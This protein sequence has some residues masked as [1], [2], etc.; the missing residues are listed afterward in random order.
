ML[1]IIIGLC[2]SFVSAQ[3]P[4][5]QPPSVS[6][7]PRYGT[8]MNSSSTPSNPHRPRQSSGMNMYEKDRMEIEQR[9]QTA[10]QDIEEATAWYKQQQLTDYLI[11]KGFPSQQN[12]TGATAFFSAYKEISDMLEGNT[13]IDMGRAIY[14]AE[15]A[16][17]EN[18]LNYDE[19]QKDI[20]ERVQLCQRRMKEL[21]LNPK[22]NMA[23]NMIIW[24]HLCD[25]L[26]MKQPGSEN[27]ITHYP[28][29]YNYDDFQ[30]KKD[31]TSH[32]V[33]TLIRT[34]K[35]NC[36]SMPLLYLMIAEKLGAEAYLSYAPLHS[37]VKIRDKKG[38][39]YNLEITNRYM[40]SDG[41]YMN[42]NYIKSG[43]IKSK[44]YM[45]PLSKEEVI[46]AM[47]A[48]LGTYYLVR[49]G[50]DPFVI[51]CADKA[52]EHYPV[53]TQALLLKADYQTRLTLEIAER[54][55]AS[56]PEMLKQHSSKAYG[57]YEK[58]QKIYSQLDATGYEPTPVEIYENWVEHV[59]ELKRTQGN[60]R[61]L[62]TKK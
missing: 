47:A 38:K 45:S 23:L 41:H 29:E 59:E 49:Y 6:S 61:I 11:E 3:I 32:F 5:I 53:C 26:E 22:D 24:S 4:V 8:N 33:S 35:G 48:Q 12:Y 13:P 50:Y 62:K 39:W 25:T 9:N 21:K 40:L 52:L 58:M 10:M 51:K 60:E 55:Q 14:L 18:D 7:M 54:L 57:H 43:G 46:A 37:F 16:F 19:F 20:K 36:Y 42:H 30:S 31:Y 15:N 1:F 2:C 34:N 27:T 56:K 28:L 17:Y 44:I